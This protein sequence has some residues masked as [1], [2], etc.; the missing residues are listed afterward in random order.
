MLWQP[1]TLSHALEKHFPLLWFV[2]FF[3]YNW[4]HCSDGGE[5]ALIWK[6]LLWVEEHGKQ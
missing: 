2:R 6:I 5:R 4:S 3:L 1:V